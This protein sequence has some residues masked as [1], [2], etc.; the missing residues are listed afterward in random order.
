MGDLYARIYYLPERLSRT[1]QQIAD[2]TARA[3]DADT[4][5]RHLLHARCARLTIKL[6]ALQAEAARYKFTDLLSSQ[7]PIQ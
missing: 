3:A 7:E 4:A 2:C 5:D 1:R 6:A